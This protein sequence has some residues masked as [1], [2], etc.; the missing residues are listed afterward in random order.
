MSKVTLNQVRLR[1]DILSVPLSCFSK[2]C[3]IS[4]LMWYWSSDLKD[5]KH[6]CS[7]QTDSSKMVSA[8]L[9]MNLSEMIIKDTFIIPGHFK[10]LKTYLTCLKTC[11]R[12][13]TGDSFGVRNLNEAAPVEWGICALSQREAGYVWGDSCWS[14]A[15]QISG[16]NY[17]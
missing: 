8:N 14:Q 11:E 5:E 3:Q 4:N 9:Y 15:C 12:A 2:S 17:V 13:A 16:I 1:I 10:A 7:F 6:K